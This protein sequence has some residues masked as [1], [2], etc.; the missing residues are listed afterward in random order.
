[1]SLLEGEALE[2]AHAKAI[3]VAAYVCQVAG[4]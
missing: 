1:M 3:D 4:A 2:H